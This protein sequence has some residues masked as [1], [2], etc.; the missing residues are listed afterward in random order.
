[1]QETILE[2][3]TLLPASSSTAKPKLGFLGVGWIGRNRMEAIIRKDVGEVTFISD[4]ATQNAEEAA[5]SAPEATMV[6]S[7]EAMLQEPE[8]NGIVIATP[9]AFHAEQ[10]ILSLEAGKSVFCQKPLGRNVEETKRVVET[11]RRQ[12]KLL[13]V[14]FSYR[15]TAAMQ[16]VYKVVQSGELGQIY[17][18]E[19]VFHNAYGP[20]KAW[21]YE[22][23]MSGG[24]CVIDLGVHLVD[25]ALWSMNFPEVKRVQ[26]HLFAKGKPISMAEGKV[27]D[28]ATASIELEGNT[29]MQLS[30][31]WNLPTGQEAIINATFYGT[32][33]G[34]AFKNINGSFYDFVAERYCGTKTEQLCAPPDEWMGRAGVVWTERVA[35]GEG[36]DEQ[37]EEFIKVA[38]VLDKIYGR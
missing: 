29:Q 14:D 6:N 5:K 27:E 36:F 17:A 31:S 20:D 21:F 24:G 25:L 33:G 32:E 3:G 19:L 37:A 35:K 7:L 34:V 30:C 28:Y 38:K 1:M 26:S 11:A 10:S 18:V 15:F 9:S 4:T 8:V 13:G 22:Q 23:K 12:N 16:E 2:N